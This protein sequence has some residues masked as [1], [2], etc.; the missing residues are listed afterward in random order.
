MST[1]T[2]QLNFDQELL[3]ALNKSLEEK[4]NKEFDELVKSFNDRKRE[5]VAKVLLE[6]HRNFDIQKAGDCIIF[7][8]KQI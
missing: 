8:I 4:L 6:V 3:M 5:L 1:Q 2:F 7:T